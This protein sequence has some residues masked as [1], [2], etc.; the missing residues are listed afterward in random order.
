MAIF[1]VVKLGHGPAEPGRYPA[2]CMLNLWQL[3][4][5]TRTTRFIEQ[6]VLGLFV[7]T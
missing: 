5:R 3:E 4:L 2:R 7:S 6:P 1:E